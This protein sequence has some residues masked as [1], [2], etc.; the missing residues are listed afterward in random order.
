MDPVVSLALMHKAKLMF[1][2]Q[3]T[4]LAFPSSSL[5]YKKDDLSFMAGLFTPERLR[6][7][8][9]FSHILDCIPASTTLDLTSPNTLSTIY[10][11]L[12]RGTVNAIKLA[13]ATRAH[14]ADEEAA[15]QNSLQFLYTVTPDGSRSDSPATI[16]Y[17]Q[18]RDV[19]FAAQEAYKNKEIEAKYTTD[20]AMKERWTI[21]DEPSLRGKVEEV[22]HEWRAKGHRTEYENAKRTYEQFVASS[23]A[24][25][26]NEWNTQCIPSLDKLT[27]AESTQEFFPCGFS[28]LNVLDSPVWT[29]LTLTEHEVEGLA[30][31]APPEIRK[32]LA[33]DQIDL[34]IE[35]LSLEISSVVITRAWFAPEVFKARFWKFYDAA[36]VL[37]NGQIPASGDC[38]AYAV[39]LI[40]A[41]NLAITLRPQSPRNQQTLTSLK[42]SS[43][44]S[45]A[46]FRLAASQATPPP[47]QTIM[48]KSVAPAPAP[49]MIRTPP[50]AP[51]AIGASRM[52]PAPGSAR[53]A[54]MRVDTEPDQL[55][56]G[57][58][59]RSGVA[60][61][62]MQEGGFKALPVDDITPPPPPAPQV[63]MPFEKDEVWILGVIC[64]YLQLCPDPD[65]TLR[66]E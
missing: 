50:L 20:P 62:R 16:A 46:T 58:A 1:E 24:V 65:P 19:W 34:D 6:K 52:A 48:L 61:R 31:A 49:P 57:A 32:L 41:R 30:K 23:P 26:W 5:S 44:L 8:A 51:M 42:T 38:P 64:R 18:Y 59:M 9:E 35:A 33:T 63:Q 36:K 12:L 39:A 25:I 21:I 14:T 28:P 56:P 66:W 2:R 17:K 54:S 47:G 55:P 7:L 53:L 40:F 43:A 37:S 15:Y 10:Q 29:T 60:L 27:D 22:E 3:D 45:F 11:G 13:S 4:Y